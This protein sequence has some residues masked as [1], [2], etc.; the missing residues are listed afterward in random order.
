MFEA[1]WIRDSNLFME[2]FQEII[3]FM[4]YYFFIEEDGVKSIVYLLFV[5]WLFDVKY[6]IL[7]FLCSFID[8]YVMLVL[9]YI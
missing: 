4:L 8:G 7:K 3:D 5:E 1:V 2:E 9:Y 6:C